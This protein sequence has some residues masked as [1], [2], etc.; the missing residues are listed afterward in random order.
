MAAYPMQASDAKTMDVDAYMAEGGRRDRASGFRRPCA[1][2]A[3]KSVPIMCAPYR[4][5]RDRHVGEIFAYSM[6]RWLSV[7]FAY[8]CSAV[9]PI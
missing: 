6:V 2:V 9:G 7:H 1:L 3:N 8:L 5:E 4:S